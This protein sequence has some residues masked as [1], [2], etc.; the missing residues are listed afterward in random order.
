MRMKRG[1]SEAGNV[2]AYAPTPYKA[3][4]ENLVWEN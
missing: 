1:G 3:W 4:D 2:G